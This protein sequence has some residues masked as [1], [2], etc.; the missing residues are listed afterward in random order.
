MR[1]GFRE[2]LLGSYL[3]LVG[4]TASI[5]LLFLSSTLS[6]DLMRQLDQRLEAQADGAA[7]WVSLRRAEHGGADQGFD[8][9][10]SRLKG[11]V[12][13]WVTIIDPEG[14]IA[15]D[16][17]LARGDG[18]LDPLSWPEIQAARRGAV[19]RATRFTEHL[20]AD[21]YFVAVPASGGAIVRLG[22]PLGEIEAT[23]AR[24]LSRLYVATLLGLGAA[25]ALGLFAAAFFV[26]PLRTMTRA[27]EALAQGDYDVTIERGSPDEF[28]TLATTLNLLAAELRSKISELVRERD[29]LSAVLAGMVEGVVVTDDRGVVVLANPSAGKLLAGLSEGVTL[30]LEGRALSELV[31]P[32]AQGARVREV[33][34]GGRWLLA[35]SERL[36]SDDR[37]VS[38][39]LVL[40]DVTERRQLE[41]RQRDFVAN[42]S[43]ELRTPVA[44]VQG[45][46]ETLLAKPLDEGTAREFLEVIHRQAER[47]GRLVQDLLRL[48]EL[49]ARPRGEGEPLCPVSLADVGAR[50]V[51]TVGTRARA[52]QVTL[53]LELGDAPPVL[54]RAAE[55]EQVVENLVDNAIKYG[56]PAGTVT[57][58]AEPR[59]ATVVLAVLD[60]GPG[61]APEHLPHLFERFYRVDRDRSKKSGGTGLG[62]AIVERLVQGMGGT[63]GAE[64]RLGSGSRFWVEL[65]SAVTPG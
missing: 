6:D 54:A 35:T 45:Y 34:L 25:I 33:A 19:G 10:A 26:R 50:V 48:A 63:V 1:L 57:L 11:V 51:E 17:D 61:I 8:R 28:G 23:E 15:G 41:Q 38:E 27:A 7:K 56:R 42:V 37:G 64:S 22:V 12:G 47:M 52:A 30:G 32:E 18:G 31:P 44:S 65:P 20:G 2:K 49:E 58:T 62:L 4:V 29:R 9:Q 55:L 46:A 3:G 13:S 24:M 21:V 5:T 14:K 43:H 60:Q 16:S 39:V 59:G 40:H 53:L 36:S